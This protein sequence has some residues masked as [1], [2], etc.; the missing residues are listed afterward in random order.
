MAKPFFS[1]ITLCKCLSFGFC[2][3]LNL[4][5]FDCFAVLSLRR[6]RK[7]I[8]TK[9]RLFFE[10]YICYFGDNHSH[11]Q[12]LLFK[13]WTTS[14]INLN[15]LFQYPKPNLSFESEPNLSQSEP[16][17]SILNPFFQIG[18]HSLESEPTRPK[19]EPI[20]SIWP[21]FKSKLSLLFQIWT[22]LQNWNPLFQN[23]SSLFQPF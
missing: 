2:L 15:L 9:N 16:N 17:L 13:I 20:F 12:N 18:T 19:S 11:F 7:P 14:F 3:A 22:H 10:V 1:F 4:Q 5:R 8:Y 23:L 21:H 6:S